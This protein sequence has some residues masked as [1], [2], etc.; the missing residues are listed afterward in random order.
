MGQRR[1]GLEPRRRGDRGRRGQSPGRG[2][3]RAGRGR[4]GLHRSLAPRT[5]RPHSP[6]WRGPLPPA[7]PR[8]SLCS[9]RL[10]GGPCLGPVPCAGPRR[11]L[12]PP[13]APLAAVRS[14]A[15]L[16]AAATGAGPQR[17]RAGG[18]ANGEAP[19]GSAAP[20]HQQVSPTL[21]IARF[22]GMGR[23]RAAENPA[24]E[25]EGSTATGLRTRAPPSLT[26][27]VPDT[28]TQCVAFTHKQPLSYTNTPVTSSGAQLPCFTYLATPTPQRQWP[29]QA[30]IMKGITVQDAG[31]SVGDL[32]RTGASPPAL[33]GCYPQ[34]HACC[35]LH[36]SMCPRWVVDSHLC[37]HTLRGL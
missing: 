21:H 12:P 31:V 16:L 8:L 6:A 7:S 24:K 10:S 18:G 2:R 4:R 20:A 13:C 19:V 30:M 14:L 36:N 3:D 22:G 29:G 15:A 1:R 27:R 28:H 33:P 5:P 35:S 34:L 26:S 23:W 9:A 11:A 32:D 37:T 25:N 17:G